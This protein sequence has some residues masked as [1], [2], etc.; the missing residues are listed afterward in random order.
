M[1]HYKIKAQFY[2]IERF[3]FLESIFKRFSQKAR[4]QIMVLIIDKIK[5]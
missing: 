4:H 3:M 2:C 1:I 5:W